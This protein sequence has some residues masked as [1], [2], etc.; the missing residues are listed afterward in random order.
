[1]SPSHAAGLVQM[2]VRTFQQF[3]AS[4]QQ[5]FSSL[6]LNAA[7]IRIHGVT[8]GALVNP[9]LGRAIRFTDVGA[10]A[11]VVE[12]PDLRS[13]VIAL[14]RHQLARD[15]DRLVGRLLD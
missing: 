6:A 11:H 7:P 3:A 15:L 8:F 1:M 14:V 9:P 13:A 2:R 4:S 12:L 5:S 10:E